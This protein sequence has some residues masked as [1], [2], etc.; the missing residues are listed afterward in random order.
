MPQLTPI[1]LKAS[2]SLPKPWVRSEAQS[3]SGSAWITPVSLLASC[4]VARAGSATVTRPSPSTG[5]TASHQAET[6]SCSTGAQA[7]PRPASAS[8]AA[9]V[10]PEVKMM[11]APSAPSAAAIWLRARS[12]SAFAARPSACTLEGLPETSIAAIIAAFASGRSG[13]VAF[14]SR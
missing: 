8:A 2:G 7:I 5:S 10:A 12:I 4:S 6:A 11:S 1:Q 3:P 13:V 14:Q 9:S